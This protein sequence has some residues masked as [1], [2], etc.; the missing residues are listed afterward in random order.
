MCLESFLVPP[1]GNAGD[2]K[3]EMTT[4]DEIHEQIEGPIRDAHT[5]ARRDAISYIVHN[6]TCSPDE[7][8]DVRRAINIRWNLKW[9][10]CDA[11]ISEV[12]ESAEREIERARAE[13]DKDEQERAKCESLAALFM[14]LGLKVIEVNG[15]YEVCGFTE[16]QLRLVAD[17]LTGADE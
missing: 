7:R 14:A 16:T 17:I 1:R 9:T 12:K 11:V 13:H 5:G 3:P 10:E 4:A 8:I 2:G 6:A 15:C